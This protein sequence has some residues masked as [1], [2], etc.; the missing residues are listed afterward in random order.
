MRIFL[1]V[2]GLAIFL[3]TAKFGYFLL[4]AEKL[5][6]SE[7]VSLLVAFA[8]IGLI[9]SFASEIQEFSV[10]GNIDLL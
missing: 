6:G 1:S 10:A 5:S 8:M 2:L 3:V 7:F 9:L 4:L